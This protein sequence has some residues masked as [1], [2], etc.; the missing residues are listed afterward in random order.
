MTV[1]QITYMVLDELK[2]FSDDA[3][4]TEEHVIFLLSKLRAFLLKQRYGTDIKKPIPES[5]YTTIC[6]DLEEVP[7]EKSV[8]YTGPRLRSTIQIPA[9]MKIGNKRI[10]PVNDF[11][12]IY[13]TIVSRDRFNYVGVNRWLKNIIYATKGPD[14]RLYLKSSNP[15]HLYLKK[16]CLNAIFE[17][18]ERASEL[19]C[20][21]FSSITDST[22]TSECP[23]KDMLDREFPIEESLVS[24]LIELV[25]KELAQAIYR[26]EDTIN[27]AQD[28][29]SKIGLATSKTN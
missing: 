1:R 17:E 3:H 11:T 5:N 14:S 12:P 7:I 19:A 18:F 27:N 16:I 4:F 8:C 23:I 20:D 6:L 24:P 26:P 28:D 15:Q 9:M 29:L 22:D 10:F 13:F 25:V 21:S 2:S